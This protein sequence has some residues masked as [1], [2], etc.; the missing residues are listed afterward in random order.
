MFAG[1]PYLTLVIN[2][3]ERF[4][5]VNGDSA[6]T[7]GLRILP[8]LGT[9]AFG[10]LLGGSINKKENRSGWTLIAG[11]VLMVVGTGLLLLLGDSAAISPSVYGFQTLFG[12]GVGL[13]LSSATMMTTFNAAREH[14]AAAHGAIAQVRVLGGT[15]ALAICTVIF[16]ARVQ[17]DLAGS[18]FLTPQ[19]LEALHRSPTAALGFPPPLR[20][21]VRATYAAAFTEQMRA[22]VVFATLAV[23]ASL[24]AWERNPTSIQESM[25]RHQ[26]F[27]AHLGETERDDVASIQLSRRL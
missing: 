24:L 8:L 5:I 2:L 3:P 18:P 11:S 9:C 13:S 23:L 16:N 17:C 15:V 25:T 27:A 20:E 22:M 26:G 12:L 4:Q 10:C 19:E 1:F 7:A 14:L 6:M 21:L